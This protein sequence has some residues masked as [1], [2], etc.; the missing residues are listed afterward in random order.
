MNNAPTLL[1]SNTDLSKIS[2][3]ANDWAADDPT[4]MRVPKQKGFKITTNTSRAVFE[5]VKSTPYKPRKDIVDALLAKGYKNSSVQSLL[6]Q[7]TVCG[8]LARD[9]H[10][11]Y[12]CV[13]AEYAPVKLSE[14]RKARNRSSKEK[15]KLMAEAKAIVKAK[16]GLA[17]LQA[18]ATSAVPVFVPPASAVRPALATEQFT[19]NNFDADR[20]LSTLS[21]NQ[22]IELY[23]KLKTMLGELG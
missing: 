21:F 9:T 14:L 19:I 23:K 13:R 16:Q 4:E 6:T 17:A 1:S 18:E 3:L 20:L 8:I 2:A 11:R 10:R 15:A 5:Q 12:Y 7:M 22:T